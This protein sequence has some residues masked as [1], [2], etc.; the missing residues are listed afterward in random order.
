MAWAR[1]QLAIAHRT[2]LAA[3]RL[4]G[5]ADPK[6]VPKPL[7]EIDDAPAHDAMHRRYRPALDRRYQ[8]PP[9]NGVQTRRLT[10]R[11]AVDQ[12]I[13]AI[14]V[15]L[16]HPVP[17]DLSRHPANLCGLGTRRPV[18]D[19]RQR[20]QSAHLIGVLA[21]ARRYTDRPRVII[22]AQWDRHGKTPRFASL[23]SDPLRVGE[24]PRVRLSKAW[25]KMP[26]SISCCKRSRILG[27][28]YPSPQDVASRAVNRA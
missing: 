28:S 12:S 22:R 21:L 13:R 14:G 18:I 16:Q 17:D 27:Q 3:E 6:L 2:Q 4:V 23:E 20:Q 9:M 24:A 19:G 10:R 1:R 8:P 25:Y 11:L 5:D 15:E 26:S 7:T